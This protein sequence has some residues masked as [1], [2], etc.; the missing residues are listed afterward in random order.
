MCSA[1]DLSSTATA[2]PSRALQPS[3]AWH[4]ALP[5]AVLGCDGGA[6]VGPLRAAAA[7]VL[8]GRMGCTLASPSLEAPA[9]AL[10]N[11]QAK[12]GVLAPRLMSAAAWAR[13]TPHLRTGTPQ[14]TN[15]LAVICWLA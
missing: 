11:K 6:A 2:I 1:A 10:P 15:A 3:P 7:A 8:E 5:L 12:G 14:C 9:A 13:E 4:Y